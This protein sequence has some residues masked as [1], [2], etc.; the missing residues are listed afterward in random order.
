M[1]FDDDDEDSEAVDVENNLRIRHEFA[2]PEG[3]KVSSAHYVVKI[4]TYC[5]LHHV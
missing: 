5:G 4:L 1:L 2:G 3:F